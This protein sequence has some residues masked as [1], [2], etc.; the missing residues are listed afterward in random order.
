[1][2]LYIPAG[3]RKRNALLVAGAALVLGLVL[4]W[5]IGRAQ[6]PSVADK[7]ASVQRDADD[8]VTRVGALPIEY[9]QGFAGTGDSI[10]KGVLVPVGTIQRDTVTLLD[11]A[12][13]IS[14]SGRNAA[15]DAVASV[16]QAASDKVRPLRFATVVRLAQADLRKAFGRS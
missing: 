9:E 4:G 10:D 8:L 2:A 13:W 11:R 7:V 12:P 5:A 15:L 1:M 3:R 16:K 6:A 14:Q